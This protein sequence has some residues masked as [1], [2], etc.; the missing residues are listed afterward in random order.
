MSEQLEQERWQQKWLQKRVSLSDERYHKLWEEAFDQ[1]A[2]ARRASAAAAAAERSHGEAGTQTESL[3]TE[4][5]SSQTPAAALAESSTQTGWEEEPEETV[6]SSAGTKAAWVEE[7]EE[8]RDVD[9]DAGG[10]D[11]L[12][13]LFSRLDPEEAL[14]V[15]SEERPQASA[16][17][18][19]PAEEACSGSP[20]PGA[21]VAAAQS[22][23]AE[24]RIRIP[25]RE[26]QRRKSKAREVVRLNNTLAEEDEGEDGDDLPGQDG[27][28]ALLPCEELS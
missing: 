7:E 26:P 22:D 9:D 27:G 1:Q 25:P 19:A 3:R 21:A 23:D 15:S 6:S 10:R 16:L 14:T 5:G 8:P 17:A 4:E 13:V 2:G 24:A 11:Q 18:S 28:Y 20:R 12:P